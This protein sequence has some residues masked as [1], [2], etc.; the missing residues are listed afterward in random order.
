MQYEIPKQISIFIEIQC[1]GPGDCSNQGTCE[2]STGACTCN[3]GFQGDTCQGK[4]I[5]YSTNVRWT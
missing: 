5:L 1:F 2:V 3:P 4:T